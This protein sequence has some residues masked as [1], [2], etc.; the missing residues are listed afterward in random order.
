MLWL[1]GP[2]GVAAGYLH[3]HRIQGRALLPGAAMFEMAAAAARCMSTHSADSL[4]VGVS[5]SA[6]LPLSNPGQAAAAEHT[7]PVLVCAANLGS[8][9]LEVRSS[10][11]A[12][13]ARSQ[14]HLGGWAGHASMLAAS[15]TPQQQAQEG[16]IGR[17]LQG[18]QHLARMQHQLQQPTAVACL[19][20]APLDGGGQPGCYAVHPAA[21]DAATHTAGAFAGTSND[22]GTACTNA[23]LSICPLA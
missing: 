18:L 10:L 3:D 6:P 11:A 9:R 17:A 5:I 14:L 2:S 20:P 15:R 13:I 4:L 22:A 8:G 1:T 12:S 16:A 19:L 23:G 7:L 21:L